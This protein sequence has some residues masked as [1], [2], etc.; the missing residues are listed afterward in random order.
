M[1]VCIHAAP[2][3]EG[4]GE[5]GGPGKG[6][7]VVPKPNRRR[8]PR[9]FTHRLSDDFFLYRL[10]PVI[11]FVIVAG[12]KGA[13][14]DASALGG[15][16]TFKTGWASCYNA[17]LHGSFDWY[18]VKDGS[19]SHLKVRNGISSQIVRFDNKQHTCNLKVFKKMLGDRIRTSSRVEKVR[20]G[21]DGKGMTIQVAGE[22]PRQ[23]DAVVMALQPTDIATAMGEEAP[24][25][26]T[27]ITTEEITVAVHRFEPNRV[28]SNPDRH[29]STLVWSLA[30]FAP[31]HLHTHTH[32]PPPAYSCPSITNGWSPILVCSP[33]TQTTSFATRQ[34]R[35][36]HAQGGRGAAYEGTVG[37]PAKH[38]LR[39]K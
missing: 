37:G 17:E 6:G 39:R 3:T 29:R 10:Y 35:A 28:Q 7:R 23:F 33:P 8:L 34:R 4:G 36:V 2:R 11:R 16:A 5:R 9:H 22:S 12:S 26:L 38:D 19:E 31:P 1:F 32:P 25:W 15:M 18:T 27:K 24:E 20:E 21:K 13:M 30:L 14:L